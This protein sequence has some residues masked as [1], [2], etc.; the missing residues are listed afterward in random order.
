MKRIEKK[1]GQ[2]GIFIGYCPL[3]YIFFYNS[4]F[5]I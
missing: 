2:S 5:K 4:S 1:N 3:F